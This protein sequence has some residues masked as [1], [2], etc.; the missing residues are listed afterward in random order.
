MENKDYDSD[1]FLYKIQKWGTLNPDIRFLLYTD[2]T[3]ENSGSSSFDYTILAV[4]NDSL[5]FTRKLNWVNYF[6]LSVSHALTEKEEKNVI[7]V[8]YEKGPKVKFV[9]FE[10]NLPQNATTLKYSKV[11]VDKQ[12]Q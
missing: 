2:H 11:L 6:G 9:L 4:V 12:G 10:S 5:D 8:V 3:T 7:D 1:K